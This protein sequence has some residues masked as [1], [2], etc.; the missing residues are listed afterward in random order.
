MAKRKQQQPKRKQQ[1]TKQTFASAYE[2]YQKIAH[3][4]ARRVPWPQL[5]QF[6]EGSLR[7][8]VFVLGPGA[9]DL[10]ICEMD[11][12]SME[13]V[14]KLSF[15]SDALIERPRFSICLL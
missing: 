1:Q 13:A 4:E 2:R 12:C 11:C 3:D 9:F 6:V 5:I 8:E 10:S 15:T 7:W 14:H